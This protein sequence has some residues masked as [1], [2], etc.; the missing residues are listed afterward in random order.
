MWWCL[1]RI[2]KERKKETRDVEKLWT[3]MFFFLSLV[4]AFGWNVCMYGYK[5][6]KDM[7]T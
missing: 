6:G 7:P 2:K 4:L 1:V 5:T 3:Q